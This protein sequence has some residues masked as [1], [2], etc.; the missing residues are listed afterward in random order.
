MK[1]KALQTE[2]L[3]KKLVEQL[4]NNELDKALALSNK[5][6]KEFQKQFKLNEADTQNPNKPADP[7]DPLAAM[8]AA[9]SNPAGIPQT[10]PAASPGATPAPTDPSAQQNPPTDSINPGEDSQPPTE[11]PKNPLEDITS[12]AKE[13]SKQTRDVPTILKAVKAKMQDNYKQLSSPKEVVQSLKNT[14]D[15]ILA[16]V[17]QRLEQFL[18][19]G[20]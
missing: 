14:R 13:L 9:G 15:P 17:A 16:S 11:E 8:D 19:A 6:R 3:L 12:T 1:N 10:N 20:K 7:N 5:R 4:V 18:K 2:S